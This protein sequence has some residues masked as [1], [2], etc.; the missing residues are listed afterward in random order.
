MFIIKDT[1]AWSNL[2]CVVNE[3]GY[4]VTGA[5]PWWPH[6]G[7]INNSDEYSWCTPVKQELWHSTYSQV[8]KASW[9]IFLCYCWVIWQ[10]KKRK[11][12]WHVSTGEHKT[13]KC[14]VEVETHPGLPDTRAFHRAHSTHCWRFSHL[15]ITLDILFFTFLEDKIFHFF[16]LRIL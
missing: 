16:S 9:Q 6:Q 5:D 4:E 11:E 1:L 10:R 2:V 13:T 14:R 7:G 15:K 3:P 12:Q 8:L